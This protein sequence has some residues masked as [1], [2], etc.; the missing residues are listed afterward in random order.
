V[1]T[2]AKCRRWA[3]GF[4]DADGAR[5]V[6]TANARWRFAQAAQRSKLYTSDREGWDE[7][8]AGQAGHAGVGRTQIGN[9]LSFKNGERQRRRV[10]EGKY[11][12]VEIAREAEAGRCLGARR[13][14]RALYLP[15]TPPPPGVGDGARTKD[16]RRG[17]HDHGDQRVVVMFSDG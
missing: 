17:G 7:L 5:C 15:R 16:W 3:A 2:W 1:G 9:Q 6:R 11:P 4:E 13:P 14:R 12:V 8:A 10:I